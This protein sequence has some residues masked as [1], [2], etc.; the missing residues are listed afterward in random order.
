L[1]RQFIPFP[2][3][4]IEIGVRL[5]IAWEN[6][7]LGIPAKSSAQPAGDVAEVAREA[8]AAYDAAI[9]AQRRGDWARYGQEI[10]RLGQLLRRLRVQ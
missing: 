6:F 2:S 8:S 10:E 1:L 3:R 5:V 9:E 4:D 7:L